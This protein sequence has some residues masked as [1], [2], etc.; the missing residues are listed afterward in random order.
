LISAPNRWTSEDRQ[1]LRGP[2]ALLELAR[3]TQVVNVV[4]ELIEPRHGAATAIQAPPADAV[5]R[6]VTR[7]VTVERRRSM[8]MP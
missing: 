2:A 1:R 8:I 6:R 3:R 5:H 7:P 4:A